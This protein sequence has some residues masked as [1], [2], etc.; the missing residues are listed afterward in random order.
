[1]NAFLHDLD[2]TGLAVWENVADSVTQSFGLSRQA[3]AD[4]DV[5]AI[6]DT[7]IRFFIL[8]LLGGR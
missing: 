8:Y 4:E 5:T 1:M 2:H 3:G 6:A 7:R